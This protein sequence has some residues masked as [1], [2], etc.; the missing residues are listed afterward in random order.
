MKSVYGFSCSVEKLNSQA[1][2]IKM[3]NKYCA[4]SLHCL[5]I[6]SEGRQ[7]LGWSFGAINGWM[8]FR[9]LPW[10]SFHL[11]LIVALFPFPL[12]KAGSTC[13]IISYIFW[14]N[15]LR[16]TD[17]FTSALFYTLKVCMVCSVNSMWF[18]LL[19][20]FSSLKQ[21]LWN[22]SKDPVPKSTCFDVLLSLIRFVT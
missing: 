12:K 11:W 14:S 16:Q 20:F 1:L 13:S 8:G 17:L 7:C 4:S 6:T 3:Q 22:S 5:L 18:V 10:G 19:V 2:C 9:L 21:C 15:F